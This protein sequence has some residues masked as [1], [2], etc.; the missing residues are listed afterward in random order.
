MV[1]WSRSGSFTAT[2]EP[3]NKAGLDEHD[4]I[5]KYQKLSKALSILHHSTMYSYNFLY[6]Y[7]YNIHIYIYIHIY[8][9]IYIIIYIFMYMLKFLHREV[10][11]NLRWMHVDCA[12]D[13]NDQGTAVNLNMRSPL[14]VFVGCTHS[15]TESDGWWVVYPSKSTMLA[16]QKNVW[17]KRWQCES[18]GLDPLSWQSHDF[19][20]GRCFWMPA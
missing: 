4:K 2:L 10:N 1:S 3:P 14:M 15:G 11:L 5:K 20:G 16:C 8:L 7:I 9:I 19:L 6:I 17:G 13:S 12:S 18:I